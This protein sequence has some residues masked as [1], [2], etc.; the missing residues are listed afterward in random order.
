LRLSN[1]A[2]A[3]FHTRPLPI[4]R[5]GSTLSS[6]RCECHPLIRRFQILEQ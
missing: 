1:R 6:V 5:L 4:E 2:A 3:F